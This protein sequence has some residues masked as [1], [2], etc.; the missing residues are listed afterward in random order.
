PGSA[1]DGDRHSGTLLRGKGGRQSLA[2]GVQR[3]RTG[4]RGSRGG[5]RGSAGRRRTDGRLAGG[6]GTGSGAADP[7]L[8]RPAGSRTGASAG[9]DEPARTG[10]GCAAERVADRAMS[11]A[12]GL[13]AGGVRPAS[14][15]AGASES[16][17]QLGRLLSAAGLRR[18]A[19][20]LP[21]R[22][23]M[24]DD[25]LAGAVRGGRRSGGRCA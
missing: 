11:A 21:R 17:V 23:A 2:P 13:P 12:L 9:S 24:E 22:A 18:S 7:Y 5:R 6:A 8:L 20:P 19:G 3:A 4:R 14:P 10:A 25:L 1:L 16:L 15:V